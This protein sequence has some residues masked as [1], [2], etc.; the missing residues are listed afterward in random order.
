MP[1]LMPRAAQENIERFSRA[2]DPKKTIL[3]AVGDVSGVDVMFNAV[4]V[5]LYVRPEKTAG[6]IIRP[7]DNVQEDLW[8]GKVGLVVKVGADAFQ[9]NEVNKFGDQ[10]V[11]VGDWVGFKVG[12]SWPFLYNNVPCRYVIDTSIRLKLSDPSILV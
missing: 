8:Q 10:R 5:A 3:H 6:G 9:D 7:H 11:E 1:L 4:L 2:L 12:D